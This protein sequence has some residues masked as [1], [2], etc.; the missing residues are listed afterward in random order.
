[1]F[2]I[3]TPGVDGQYLDPITNQVG[4]RKGGHSFVMD[5]GT[6]VNNASNKKGKDQL[7]R[8][9]TAGGHQLLMNDTEDVMYIGN[10]TG[11]VWMEFTGDGKIHVFS[12]SDFSLR[13]KGN[14]NIHSDKSINMFAHDDIKMFAGT[15]IQE[16]SELI[17]LK[18]TTELKE[19]GGKI[20]VKSAS[21]WNVI[22]GTEATMGSGTQI[23][24]ASGMIYLNTKPATEVE[25][26]PN[27]PIAE[28]LEPTPP[29]APALKWKHTGG[30]F[31]STIPLAP[32]PLPTHEP[33]VKHK[34]STSGTVTKTPGASSIPDNAVRTGSG[35]ILVDGSGN[36]VTSGA[37]VQPG[38]SSAS[39][40][41]VKNQASA[42]DLVKQP[43][44]TVAIGVLSVEDM[45]A[46]KAQL[47]RSES[48]FNYSAQNSIGYIGKYQFGVQALETYGYIKKG[49]WAT[50]KKN[51]AVNDPANWVGTNGITSKEAFFGAPE[52]QEQ[53]MDRNLKANYSSLINKGIITTESTAEDVAGKLAVAHLLGAGGCSKWCNGGV[54]ADAYGTTGGMYYNAGRYAIASL[55]PQVK[56]PTETA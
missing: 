33:Y 34:T 29:S 30:K 45:T 31:S 23:V 40:Q 36:P 16:Q 48:N 4:Y 54:G 26:H 32:T 1:V 21:Q 2:G 28:H 7:I 22:A 49:T 56:P 20:N 14:F 52:I 46:L 10:S 53:L 18:A 6:P 43:I 24:Y 8:L 25:T 15:S 50:Y 9:R 35:G 27:I 47:G 17:S 41:G 13:T 38:P 19:Y 39:G 3:S 44:S 37:V 12:E 42:G 5:D 55:S 51:T 11:S